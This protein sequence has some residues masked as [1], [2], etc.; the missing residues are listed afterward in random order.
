M[1]NSFYD[2]KAKRWESGQWLLGYLFLSGVLFWLIVHQ[3]EVLRKWTIFLFVRLA[4]QSHTS[5][6]RMGYSWRSLFPFS[7]SDKIPPTGA[8]IKI[9]TTSGKSVISFSTWH[10][11]S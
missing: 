4:I 8:F 3:T 5:W 6:L 7:L 1:Q 2:I 11:Y 10:L 9:F